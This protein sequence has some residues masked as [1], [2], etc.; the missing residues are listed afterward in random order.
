MM[1]FLTTS[2][3]SLSLWNHPDFHS[4]KEFRQSQIREARI[5][6]LEDMLRKIYLNEMMAVA[7]TD[8]DKTS[9]D[10]K[11]VQSSL[12]RIIRQTEAPT[13][14]PEPEVEEPKPEAG[15]KKE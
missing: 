2:T 12:V 14:G 15:S 4:F 11:P 13:Q 1:I 9:D 10:K 8:F 6:Q 3:Q 7:E 5:S